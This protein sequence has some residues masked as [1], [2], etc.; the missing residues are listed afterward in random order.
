MDDLYDILQE[1]VIDQLG[2]MIMYNKKPQLTAST[3]NEKIQSVDFEIYI[4]KL[5]NV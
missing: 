3:H 2:E 5:K 4:A 1:H